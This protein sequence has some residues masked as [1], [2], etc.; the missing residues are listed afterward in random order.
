MELPEQVAMIVPRRSGRTDRQAERSPE[1]LRKFGIESV[2]TFTKKLAEKLSRNHEP[3]VLVRSV[4][5]HSVVDREGIKNDLLITAVMSQAV[6][7]V[8]E[9]VEELAQYDPTEGI[10]VTIKQWNSNDGVWASRYE[11][12]ELPRK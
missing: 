9:L 1:V 6:A 2:A 10:R 11:F 3:G 5:R 12:L 7:S 4:R 8:D